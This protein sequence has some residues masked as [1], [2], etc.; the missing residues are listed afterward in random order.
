MK[1]MY[2]ELTKELL[3][4]VPM[5]L[6]S[7]YEGDDQKRYHLKKRWLTPLETLD[8]Q[9]LKKPVTFTET[10]EHLLMA[11]NFYPEERMIILGGGHVSMALAEFGAKTG[12]SVTVVD[13]RPAF[14]D[15][16]CFVCAKQVICDAFTSAIEKLG[17]T[18][19]DYVIIVTRGHRYDQECLEALLSKEEPRYTGMMGSKRR[20]KAMKEL[21]LENGYDPDR[22]EHLHTPIG[23]SIGALTP[24]EIAI[25]VMAEIISEKRLGHTG[26][27]MQRQN[28]AD[29]DYDVLK[30]L[31]S[32]INVKK[33]VVTI[34]ETKG[35]VPR[36]A[37]AKMLVYETGRTVGSIGGG[38]SEALIMREALTF[39]GTRKAGLS[40]VD[41]TADLSDDE[42][43]VCGGIMSVFIE[44]YETSV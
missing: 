32:E 35:S 24:E 43:M 38:C 39:I 3:K 37:G 27:L 40:K 10:K 11:E 1:N 6:T 15:P 36:R 26:N 18:S 44:D 23:L 9:S 30:L 7:E 42:V 31:E 13:D 22:I 33:A 12:F 5:V 4:G 19:Y 16:K 29:I 2:E 34:I 41:M 20:V 21:M 8:E 14:A 28:N 25:S 17:I